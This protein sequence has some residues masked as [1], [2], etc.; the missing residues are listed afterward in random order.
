MIKNKLVIIIGGGSSGLISAI[1]AAIK[2]Y[3]VLILEYNDKPAKKIAATGNGK[4]NISNLL[5]DEN[6]FRSDNL[7]FVKKSLEIFSVKDTCNFF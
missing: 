5:M 7:D 6:Y 4:C 1:I 2:G 3:N